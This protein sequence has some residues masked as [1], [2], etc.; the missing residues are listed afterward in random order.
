[1]LEFNEIKNHMSKRRRKYMADE[2]CRTVQSLYEISLQNI[3]AQFF[4]SSMKCF[5]QIDELENITKI[6]I[7][8]YEPLRNL[9]CSS[10][11]LSKLT[12]A[13][14]DDNYYEV[15]YE[16]EDP[17]LDDNTKKSRALKILYWKCFENEA[18][19]NLLLALSKKHRD[20]R[21]VDMDVSNT[22]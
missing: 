17:N 1:M 21:N 11:G 5:H 16:L 14:F 6:L 19:T 15:V 7:D 2:E 3:M 20:I 18:V 10:Y 8:Y 13:M 9:S 12:K 22:K 4:Y